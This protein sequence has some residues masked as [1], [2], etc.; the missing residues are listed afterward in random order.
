MGDLAGDA[1]FTVETLEGA[2][3]VGAGIGQE[4]ESDGLGE[5]EIGGAVD[6]AH[7]AAAEQGDDAVASG[8][9]GAGD[10]AAF[11]GGGE[12]GERGGRRDDDGGRLGLYGGVH[13]A[14]SG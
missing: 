14:Y 6:F 13:G 11:I 10:E 5:R 3:V 9:Q 2:L 8:D 7:A 4:L 1:D 12:G